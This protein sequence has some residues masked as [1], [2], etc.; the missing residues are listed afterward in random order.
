LKL[1]TQATEAPGHLRVSIGGMGALLHSSWSSPES[2]PRTRPTGPETD[3]RAVE[4]TKHSN[5]TEESR[6]RV[7][8]WCASRTAI[9]AKSR[10][11]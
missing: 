8:R 9:K 5:K 3:P 1:S 10:Q 7:G 2:F 11:R 4:N 6:Q